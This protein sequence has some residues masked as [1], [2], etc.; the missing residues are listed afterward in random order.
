MAAGGVDVQAGQ[1]LAPCR[2]V[3][4]PGLQLRIGV[5]VVDDGVQ[6]GLGDQHLAAL[7]QLD[8]AAKHGPG[9]VAVHERLGIAV[10]EQVVDH[11]MVRLP[12]AEDAIHGLSHSA[13]NAAAGA[14]EPDHQMVHAG[15]PRLLVAA[16]ARDKLFRETARRAT[17]VEPSG[18]LIQ[19]LRR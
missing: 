18:R 2:A 11:R 7:G 9:G 15:Q 3:A 4:D 6:V 19:S 1:D 10:H 8:R 14:A 17:S 12:L 13:E 16:I 5:Q